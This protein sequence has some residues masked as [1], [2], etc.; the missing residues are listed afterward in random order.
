M[1]RFPSLTQFLNTYLSFDFKLLP[2]FKGKF[3]VRLGRY[4]LV[5]ISSSSFSTGRKGFFRIKSLITFSTAPGPYSAIY[6]GFA[7]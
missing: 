3:R 5:Y 6:V 7:P 4:M 2:T 1:D